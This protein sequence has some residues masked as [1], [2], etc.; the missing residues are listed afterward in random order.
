MFIEDL[1]LFQ[2]AL[3]RHT[4]HDADIRAFAAISGDDNPL[5]LDDEAAK[6]SPL[7]GRAIHGALTASLVSRLLGTVLPGHG[8]IYKRQNFTFVKPVRPGE[9]VRAFA[10]I[11]DINEGSN[12]VKLDVYCH[13]KEGLVLRGN[14]EVWVPSKNA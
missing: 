3:I 8:C 11:T 12:T 6:R 2:D 13:T 10:Y 1:R 4:F 5:H 9:E 7:K 14:V